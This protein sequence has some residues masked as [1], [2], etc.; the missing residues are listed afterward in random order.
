L[1]LL[2]Q[3]IRNNNEE[4]HEQKIEELHEMSKSES[5]LLKYELKFQIFHVLL[6]FQLQ[7]LR[8]ELFLIS[9]VYL[10]FFIFIYF[11][12]KKKKKINTKLLK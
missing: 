5:K 3:V 7:G 9:V 6:T 12:L 8:M 2:K 10:Y 1:D 4:Y 11:Y